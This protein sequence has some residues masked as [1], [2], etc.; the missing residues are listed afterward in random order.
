[1]LNNEQIKKIS[2]SVTGCVT[3]WLRVGFDWR[4]HFVFLTRE[5]EIQYLQQFLTFVSCTCAQQRHF[6]GLRVEELH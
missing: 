3:C 5:I 2:S 4:R 6:G 1:M